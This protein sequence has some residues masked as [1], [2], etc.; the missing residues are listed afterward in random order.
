MLVVVVKKPLNVWCSA[1][2]C[3]LLITPTTVQANIGG[4]LF[5]FFIGITD[6]FSW[7]IEFVL[8]L[9]AVSN[10]L[11]W[12]MFNE[13]RR[14]TNTQ[15]VFAGGLVVA[16]TGAVLHWRRPMPDPEDESDSDDDSDDE[17]LSQE[18]FLKKI[19]QE[20]RELAALKALQAKR[21][22]QVPKGTLTKRNVPNKKVQEEEETS[23]F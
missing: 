6:K 15:A 16:L 12:Y 3:S 17:E 10:A 20:E 8:L 19:Q 11:W 7:L 1:I 4:T 14:S 22:A 13:L 9:C 2:W 23:N 5:F 18:Q 21:L